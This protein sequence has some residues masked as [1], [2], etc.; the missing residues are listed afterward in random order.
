MASLIQLVAAAFLALSVS[1]MAN[2]LAVRDSSDC[3]ASCI[4]T[5]TITL[6]PTASV[7]TASSDLTTSLPFSSGIVDPSPPIKT[8]V[9]VQPSVVPVAANNCHH[10][11]CLRQFLRHPQDTGF[12]ATYTTTINTATT[13]L[14]D[15]VSQCHVDPTRISSACS[16]IVTGGVL[17][18]ASARQSQK[19]DGTFTTRSH[20][21]HHSHSDMPAP[22]SSLESDMRMESIVYETLTQTTTYLVTITGSPMSTSNS[23]DTTTLAISSPLISNIFTNPAAASSAA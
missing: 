22:T 15:Y 8:S 20:H 16:C 3:P 5:T 9:L 7:T 14:A 13:D 23:T 10:N 11:N 18:T 1:V 19:D 2:P 6:V 4:M 17:P 21:H 12:C